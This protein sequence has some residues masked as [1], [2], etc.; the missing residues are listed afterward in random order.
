MRRFFSYLIAAA[1]AASAVPA[2]AHWQYTRWGMTP[3]QVQAANPGLR[4]GEDRDNSFE[5]SLV[6]LSGTYTE[7][8]RSYLVRFGFDAANRLNT[9]FLEPRN[10]RDCRRIITELSSRHGRG[11]IDTDI[12][13]IIN[14]RT[15]HDS[16][17]GNQIQTYRIGEDRNPMTCSVRYHPPEGPGDPPAPAGKP[18]AAN[19]STI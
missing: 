13:R 7:G 14:I 10:L 3:E 15:W 2:G 16:A 11:T 4:A 9:V 1:A 12:P 5:G 18:G 17:G 6:R 19:N 8:G